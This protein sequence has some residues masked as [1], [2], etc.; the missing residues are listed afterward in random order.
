MKKNYEKMIKDLEDGIQPVKHR[1]I[2]KV[3][4]FL[5]AVLSIGILLLMFLGVFALIKLLITYLFGG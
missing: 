2:Y 1:W 5:G 4:G 3:F